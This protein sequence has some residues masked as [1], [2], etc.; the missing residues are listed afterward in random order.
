MAEYRNLQPKSWPRGTAGTPYAINGTGCSGGPLANCV[1]FSQYFIN[2][3]TTKKY[4]H[5]SDGRGVVKD[6]LGM[7]FTDG[8]H[9]P[10]AYAIFSRNSGTYGHTGVV[11]GIDTANNSILIGEASCGDPLSQV[12]AH[13]YKLSKFSSGDYTYAYTDGL[14]KGGVLQ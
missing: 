14:L 12:D 8:G 9:T 11:L 6:L 7:G 1:A 10:K 4:V 3:Y 2:R 13:V 5:T